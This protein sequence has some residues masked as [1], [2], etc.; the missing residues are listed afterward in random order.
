MVTPP[1]KSST[2]I[3]VIETPINYPY[4]VESTLDSS[5]QRTT[6][7]QLIPSGLRP[8]MS[9]MTLKQHLKVTMMRLPPKKL[10]KALEVSS[11]KITTRR[12]GKGHKFVA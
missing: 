6:S 1:E 9:K 12:K 4:I 11:N 5:P 3:D 8:V 2:I 7:Q 10:K